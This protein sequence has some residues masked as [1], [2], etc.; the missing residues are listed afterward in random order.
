M[1]KTQAELHPFPVISSYLFKLTTDEIIKIF[2][3]TGLNIDWDFANIESSTNVARK[4]V[5]IP[6]I[7][8]AYNKLSD[9]KKLIVA[10]IIGTALAKQTDI[11]D[12]LKNALSHIGW[13]LELDRLTTDDIDIKEMFF[14]KGKQYD[15]YVGIKSILQQATKSV[16]IVDGYLD[17]SI[18]LMLA[19]IPTANIQV[20]FLS[21]N[22]LPSDFALEAKKFQAQHTNFAI[23]IKTNKEFHDRFV[24]LDNQS[25]YHL[26]ASIK[27]AGNKAFM[28]SKIEDP[29][30]SS[31]LLSALTQSW[32][33][34][35]PVI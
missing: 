19:T 14:S 28:I 4:R 8:A 27:D 7:Q 12:D 13:K 11:A 23:E 3:L 15:A 5:Y 1:V 25:C 6:R 24:I 10:W 33:L 34:A 31:V 29:Q 26:G 21:S 2:G 32:T 22:K 18:F 35:T 9:E 30:I 20:Q 17:N 16:T